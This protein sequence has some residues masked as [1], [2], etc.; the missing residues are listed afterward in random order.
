MR[1]KT[2]LPKGIEHGLLGYNFYLV[3]VLINICCNCFCRGEEGKGTIMGAL[4]NM[5]GAIKSKLAGATTPSDDETRAAARGDE[6]M[7]TGKTTVTV[8]VKDTRPGHVATSLKTSDQMS[9]Q[10]FND[11]GEM[12]EEAGR[13]KVVVEEKGKL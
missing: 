8:D 10:T 4:G 5:T 7:G 12:D 1:L 9:G 11:V 3:N 13:G 6:G 2:P